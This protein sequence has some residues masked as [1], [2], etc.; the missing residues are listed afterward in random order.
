MIERSADGSGNGSFNPPCSSGRAQRSMYT[1]GCSGPSAPRLRVAAG[2]LLARGPVAL[3]RLEY[4]QRSAA[5]AGLSCW[6]EFSRGT[7]F[8]GLGMRRSKVEPRT[9]TT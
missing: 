4:L 5:A 6:G 8:R 2:A 1:T 3:D 9:E 7:R